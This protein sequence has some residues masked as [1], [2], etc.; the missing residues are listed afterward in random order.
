MFLIKSLELIIFFIQ[1]IVSKTKASVEEKYN[2]I[3]ELLE[4][5]KRTTIG[6]IEAEALSMETQITMQRV[7]KEAYKD[8]ITSIME[9]VDEMNCT[10]DSENVQTLQ[11]SIPVT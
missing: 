10:A 4:N 1:R 3:K 11:V 2:I 5:D 9:R 7:D 8:A 6:L